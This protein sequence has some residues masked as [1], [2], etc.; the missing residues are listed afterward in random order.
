MQRHFIGLAVKWAEVSFYSAS[1]P[2]MTALEGALRFA[3][4]L[5]DE[6]LETHILFWITRMHYC[7]GQMIRADEAFQVFERRFENDP[8][9]LLLARMR[10]THSIVYQYML[11]FQRAIDAVETALPVVEAAGDM[12][13]LIWGQGMLGCIFGLVGRF[14]ESVALTDQAYEQA[15][16]VQHKARQAMSQ[17]YGTYAPYHAGRLNEAIA[18]GENAVRLGTQAQ[19]DVPVIFGHFNI[20][21]ALFL[22]GRRQEG[23]ARLRK[24]IR[25]QR[26]TG[27]TLGLTSYLGYLA[28]MLALCGEAAE[29]RRV[30]AEFNELFAQTGSRNGQYQAERALAIAGVHDGNAQWEQHFENAIRFTSETD[31]PPELAISHFRY[32]EALAT[33]GDAIGARTQLDAAETL[34][35]KLGMVW[36]LE[37]ANELRSTLV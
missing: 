24:A 8:E 15:T 6:Q 17:S 13:H 3:T 10:I 36:W 26:A 12:E 27:T 22:L 23:V 1:Q 16:E 20:G 5:G 21:T 34:F 2:N 4:Q 14:Q 35:R 7:L 19:V 29:A 31:S 25:M 37:Q 11:D 32:A 18:L 30:A 9:N 33:T 28:E